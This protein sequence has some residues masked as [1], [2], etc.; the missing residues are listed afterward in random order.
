MLSPDPSSE[1][2]TFDPSQEP[3][4]LSRQ[5]EESFQCRY[6]DVEQVHRI[7]QLS[8]RSLGTACVER[9]YGDLFKSPLSV[10]LDVKKEMLEYLDQQSLSYSSGRGATSFGGPF[11][12]AVEVAA[13]LLDNFVKSQINLLSRVSS[14]LIS[15]DR[16][17]DRIDE[18]IQELDNSGAWAVSRRQALAKALVKRLDN[19]QSSNCDMNFPTREDLAVHL[20][21]CPLRPITCA[22]GDCSHVFS[23]LHAVE[24]DGICPFKLLACEQECGTLVMRS[25][26]DKH[27]VTVCPMKLVNCPF[28]QVGC[29][30]MLAQKTVEQHC[31][32]S[33]GAHLISVL[34][35]VQKQEISVSSITQRVLLMEKALSLSQRSEAVDIGTLSL[36]VRQQ[37]AK[38]KALEQ[39]TSRLRK[40]LKAV[41]V[42]AE[43]LQLRRELQNLQKKIEN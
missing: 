17:D 8:I 26:M 14:R 36:T 6:Y 32:E 33:M 34:Q 23:A 20:G 18:V 39:E 2:P 42:S 15:S 29:S 3:S 30:N 31:K 41:N 16:K 10:V 5:D 9:T 19:S 13:D 38:I 4:F 35:N 21:I 28:L 27:C 11:P 12:D 40:E 37:D 1:V 25:E 24:H 7:A 43:V 22:N